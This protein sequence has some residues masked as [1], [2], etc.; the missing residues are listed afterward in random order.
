MKNYKLL[1]LLLPFMLLASCASTNNNPGA[2]SALP[3][4]RI[5]GNVPANSPFAKIQIGMSPAQVHSII[6]QPTDMKQ[7]I[8]GKMFIPFY[9]GS[10]R[11]RREELYKGVGRITY[12]S[13]AVFKAIYDPSEDGFQ[14]IKKY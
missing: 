11:V 2:S 5:E 7:Y 6:G 1:A 8:T 3:E 4:S 13:G 14:D 12:A 9:F 10:D